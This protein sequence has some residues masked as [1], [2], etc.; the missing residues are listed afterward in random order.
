MKANSQESQ[1]RSGKKADLAA[2][3]I[4]ACTVCGARFSALAESESCPMCMLRQALASGIESS[5]SRSEDM[6]KPSPPPSPAR[7]N[8]YQVVIHT[9]GTHLELG[10]GGLRVLGKL[11][12]S[13][14]SCVWG[15]GGNRGGTISANSIRAASMSECFCLGGTAR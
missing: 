15:M 14:M 2:R 1:H 13:E 7:F 3:E 11:K 6:P 9:D 4:R 10:R 12:L 8:H 5:G